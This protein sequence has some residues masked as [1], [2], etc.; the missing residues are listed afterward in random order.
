MITIRL[1]TSTAVL[2]AKFTT[3]GGDVNLD[4]QMCLYCE[5]EPVQLPAKF[6]SDNHRQRY[7]RLNIAE[8][9]T[10]RVTRSTS[11]L[12]EIPA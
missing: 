11:I 5:M 1:T 12:S 9:Q 4:F 2:M 6:C 8:A 7:W 3:P 10:H